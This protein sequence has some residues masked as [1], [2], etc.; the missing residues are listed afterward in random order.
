[1]YSYSIGPQL[2]MS[3]LLWIAIKMEYNKKCLKCFWLF[4]KGR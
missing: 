1:M 4:I 3:I 2:E